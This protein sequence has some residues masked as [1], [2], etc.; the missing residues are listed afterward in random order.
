MNEQ[1]SEGLDSNILSDN[2]RRVVVATILP[3][4]ARE[5]LANAAAEATQYDE[6]SLK[7]KRIIDNAISRIRLAY[8]EYFRGHRS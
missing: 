7:R 3:A 5:I 2:S 6:G 8:P 1:N 4:E